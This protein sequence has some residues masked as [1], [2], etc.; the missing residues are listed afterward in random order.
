MEELHINK[1]SFRKKPIP[2]PA[3]YRPMY[4]IAIII[5]VL[6][7]CC[8]GNSSS[9]LKLHLLSWS[10]FSSKNMDFLYNYLRSN[11]AGKKPVWNIDPALNRALTLAIA[12]GLCEITSSKKYKLTQKGQK[13]IDVLNSDKELL[14]FEKDYLKKI[15]KQRLPEDLVIR[16]S[17]INIDY[18]EN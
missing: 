8:R 7:Y 10:L 18:V 6:Y 3:E 9:L 15:G 14:D 13:F 16:L 12:D 1:I 11:Y 2:I 5:M 4:Q 17:Q